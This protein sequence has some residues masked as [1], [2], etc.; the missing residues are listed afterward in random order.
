MTGANP[1]QLKMSD[2]SNCTG[3]LIVIVWVLYIAAL[4]YVYGQVKKNY[5]LKAMKIREE[6]SKEIPTSPLFA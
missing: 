4:I 3:L 2:R 1:I 6:N 5:Q